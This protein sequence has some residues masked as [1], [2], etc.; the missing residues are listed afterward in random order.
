MRTLRITGKGHTKFSVTPPPSKVEQSIVFSDFQ[1]C[2]YVEG[3]DNAGLLPHELVNKFSGWWKPLHKDPMPASF[4]AKIMRHYDPI[5]RSWAAHALGNL[6]DEAAGGYIAEDLA[7]NDARLRRAGFE[8]I[9]G[10]TNWGWARAE[11]HISKELVTSRFLPF[12]L[13]TIKNPDAPMWEVNSALWAMANADE[14]AIVDN[15]PVILPFFHNDEW[16]LRLAA[17]EAIRPLTK[18]PETARMVLPTLLSI[19]GQEI[20]VYPLRQFDELLSN[21]LKDPN[22]PKDIKDM[23]VAGRIKAMKET[24]IDPGYTASIGLDSKYAAARCLLGSRPDVAAL[25]ADDLVALVPQFGPKHWFYV[26]WL[27][28]GDKWGNPGLIKCAAK[29]GKDAGPIIKAIKTGLPALQERRD[30]ATAKDRPQF[31][32]IIAGVTKAIADYEKLSK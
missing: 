26:I 8:A 22:M 25:M 5:I 15:L 30:A 21:M 1:K 19:I 24:V 7:S 12:I 2:D 4:Y 10:Q 29:L 13:K 6:G 3:G 20:H 18:S 31:D 32:E 17:V 16:F 14:K 9:S 28:G 11:V 23:I 27:Y